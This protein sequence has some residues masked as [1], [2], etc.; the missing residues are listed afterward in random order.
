MNSIF[1]KAIIALSLSSVRKQE[2]MTFEKEFKE[3]IS[4][5]PSKEKDKLILRLLKKDR[6]LAERLYFEL[7]DHKTVD[8]RRFDKQ[9]HIK[10][11]IA[12]FSEYRLSPGDLMMYMREI[13][14][15]ITEHVKITKDK[16]GEVSL[17]L[18]LLL[19]TL[20]KNNSQITQHTLAKARKLCIYIIGRAFKILVLRQKLHEDLWLEFDYDLEQLGELITENPSL[21][22]IAIQN[23]FDVNWLLNND[24]P[25]NIEEIH[26][27]IRSQGFLTFRIHLSTPKF[28][29]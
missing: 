10:E 20:Q 9:K 23:G 4:H 16:H 11:R 21:M 13:S 15:E 17:N 8:E 27:D 24:I 3:A 5:L 12:F 2:I 29:S 28:N 7:V 1:N 26:K 18:L 25:E 6:I 14:G 22:K 19:E